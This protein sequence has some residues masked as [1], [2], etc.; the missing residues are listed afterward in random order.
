MVREVDT[1]GSPGEQEP[2]GGCRG[3]GGGEELTAAEPEGN[4]VVDAEEVLREPARSVPGGEHEDQEPVPALATAE[5][6]QHPEQRCG[7]RHVVQR[8][9]V[10][11]GADPCRAA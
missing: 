10:H 3:D 1:G 7:A 8:R 5:H 9:L 11:T 2:S 6:E 4:G